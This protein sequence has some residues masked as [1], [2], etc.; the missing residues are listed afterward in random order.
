MSPDRY[1]LP[2]RSTVYILHEFHGVLSAPTL[3]HTPNTMT[4]HPSD[5]LQT[6][7]SGN[8]IPDP[9]QA[10][11]LR[12]GIEKTA[13]QIPQLRYQLQE[14]EDKLLQYRWA[15]S[16]LRRLPLET[17]GEII[18]IAAPDFREKGARRELLNYVLVCKSWWHASLLKHH[19][20]NRVHIHGPTY[21]QD[22]RTVGKPIFRKG[23]FNQIATWLGRAG[24]LSR[25]LKVVG[26]K[27]FRDTIC[28][29]HARSI[30][31]PWLAPTLRKLLV[32]GPQL[33]T[34][35]LARIAPICLRRLMEAIHSS[36]RSEPRT[37]DGVRTLNIVFAFNNRSR[38]L[39]LRPGV[40]QDPYILFSDLPLHL[41]TLRL[42]LP[43]V[44]DIG[45]DQF[46]NPLRI[47]QEVLAGLK[48][49]EFNSDWDILHAPRLLQFCANLEH[50]CLNFRARDPQ[51]AKYEEDKLFEVYLPNLRTF[52]LQN[53]YHKF[54]ILKFFRTPALEELDIGYD[55]IMFRHNTTVQGM[56]AEALS[57]RVPLCD[58]AALSGCQ[59]TL[60]SL[61]IYGFTAPHRF[62]P[63]ELEAISKAYPSLTQLTMDKVDIDSR[64][65]FSSFQRNLAGCETLN[66]IPPSCFPRLQKLHLLNCPIRDYCDQSLFAFL[67][68]LHHVRGGG[69]TDR[70]ELVLSFA[71][72]S[73]WEE[74]TEE[75]FSADR[76]W[77]NI[78]TQGKRMEDPVIFT[79]VE[80]EEGNSNW[81]DPFA[82]PVNLENMQF[83]TFTPMN[84]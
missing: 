10:A 38:W 51:F 54:E 8:N 15:L 73:G 33:D 57:P 81:A 53:Q 75:D 70:I 31:C 26:S 30:Q 60:R 1:V 29:G 24:S 64:Y 48:I 41:T 4:N 18:H 42:S 46:A 35:S 62:A 47:P 76:E 2:A 58:F 66:S 45:F 32:K 14:L 23:T 12:Q 13:Q 69:E 37:F 40:N 49:F 82:R 27:D 84:Q 16:P 39:E 65:F 6:L 67:R 20:W 9:V 52:R 44:H 78:D 80:A 63:E 74:L 21:E 34:I 77:D 83:A 72:G 50:L 17:I 55:K 7:L 11:S 3:S 61:R 5:I 25:T 59:H 79:L 71:D 68:R 28:K 43:S 19:L 22:D 36:K 56:S